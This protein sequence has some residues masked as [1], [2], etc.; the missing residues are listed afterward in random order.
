MANEKLQKV[1][2]DFVCLN[3]D[4]STSR[5]SSYEK[6][7][8]TDKH[9]RLINANDGQKNVQ[10]LQISQCVCGKSYKHLSSLCKHKNLCKFVIKEDH[11]KPEITAELLI[12][13]INQN[14]ELQQTLIDQNKIM[15]EHFKNGTQKTGNINTINSNNKTFNLQVFLNETCKDAINMS[16]FVN[17]LQ[18][19]LS[20][21]EETG[22]IGYAEGISKVFIKNLNDIN[23]TDRPIHC[24]DLKRETF[25][26]KDN[27]QWTKDNEQKS[28]LTKAIKQVAHKNI[29]Q[30][31]EWQKLHP[32]FSDPDSKQ[33]D[34]Y[35]KIVL[36]SMSGSTEEEQKNNINKIIR[37]V[38][39]EV[40]IEK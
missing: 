26:I 9:F 12:E 20:D 6:H 4:Y 14:K 27:N 36:N 5:K 25:Y 33:N 15:V 40:I 23:Y 32:D 8:S 21:L 22:R 38:T 17:Q 18:I 29:K 24:N 39:K 3:C 19:S 30:I 10:K 28:G 35:M 37:N 31:S 34:K 2:E 16:D 11:I 7:L 13:L 1:A